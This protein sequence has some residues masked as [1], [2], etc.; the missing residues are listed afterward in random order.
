MFLKTSQNSQEN[1]CAIVSGTSVFLWKNTPI[2]ASE[3]FS[4]KHCCGR[5]L[6]QLVQQN[7]FLIFKSSH[8]ELFCQ[9]G[10]LKN[11]TKFP[12]KHPVPEPPFNKVA[13]LR[14]EFWESF[15]TLFFTEHLWWLLLYFEVNMLLF[16]L[17]FYFAWNIIFSGVG[18]FWYS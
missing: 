7:H 4:L 18:F 14:P 11:F 10:V 8:P 5:N 2:A 12:G 17:L 3:V 9:K 1:N 13:G 15:R 6:F 16:V